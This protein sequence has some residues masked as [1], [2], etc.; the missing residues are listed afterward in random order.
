MSVNIEWKFASRAHGLLNINEQTFKGT[1]FRKMYGGTPFKINQN[2]TS[3][4]MSF[5]GN[6]TNAYSNIDIEYSDV[7]TISI[8]ASIIL[9]V[10]MGFIAWLLCRVGAW[11]R[12]GGGEERLPPT[13]F[14]SSRDVMSAPRST[15]SQMPGESSI[16]SETSTT[17]EE[18][19]IEEAQS[20]NR[21]ETST[22][23][24]EEGAVEEKHA[25]D[26]GIQLTEFK[27]T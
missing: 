15:V 12:V 6:S 20:S 13:W 3:V 27:R 23:T 16:R 14:Q 2:K 21:S 25:T 22:E 1:Y 24:M 4:S 7:V 9:T 5:F 19:D 17:I 11:R 18:S 8:L 10:T 26:A